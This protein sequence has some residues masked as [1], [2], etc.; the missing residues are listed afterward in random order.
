MG[1]RVEQPTRRRDEEP[2]DGFGQGQPVHSG[3]I[4]VDPA[5]GYVFLIEGVKV[6]RASS[7]TINGEG[8]SPKSTASFTG[9]FL[10][11]LVGTYRISGQSVMIFMEDGEGYESDS[12][13]VTPELIDGYGVR[14]SWHL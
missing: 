1:G 4:L 10:A 13:T 14:E 7:F 8:T 9:S 12:F 5:A 2:R 6:F 11:R 3:S